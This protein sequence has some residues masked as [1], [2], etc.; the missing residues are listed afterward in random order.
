MK[1]QHQHL[2]EK[3]FVAS[4]NVVSKLRNSTFTFKGTDDW[5]TIIANHHK[6]LMI[7]AI[8]TFADWLFQKNERANYTYIMSTFIL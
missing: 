1:A 2:H 3:Q 4:R 5:C 7:D 8:L 6:V